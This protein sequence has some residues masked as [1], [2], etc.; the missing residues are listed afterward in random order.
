MHILVL[1]SEKS[2]FQ[3]EEPLLLYCKISNFESLITYSKIH[4]RI[5][6]CCKPKDA[7]NQPRNPSRKFE[8][9]YFFWFLMKTPKSTKMPLYSLGDFFKNMFFYLADRRGIFVYDVYCH[10]LCR[11]WCAILWNCLQIDWPIKVGACRA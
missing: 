9:I 4:F 10:F 2:D 11:I 1:L 3:N 6:A 7:S 5:C 8:R